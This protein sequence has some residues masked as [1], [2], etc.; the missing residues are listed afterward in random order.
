MRRFKFIFVLLFMAALGVAIYLF[1]DTQ[2][3]EPTIDGLYTYSIADGAATIKSCDPTLSGN[4]IVPARLGGYPVTKIDS[5]AFND[6]TKI[7]T[8][9]LPEGLREIQ[10]YA[11][12]NCSNLI[13]V[14][15]PA[16]VTTID[17][18][19]FSNCTRLAGIWVDKANTVY[20][21]DSFGVLYSKDQKKIIRAPMNLADPYSIPDSVEDIGDRAFYGCANLKK[22]VVPDGI[23]DIDWY[24]FSNCTSLNT[25]VLPTSLVS[26]GS[27]VFRGCS[28]L[29]DVLYKG[30]EDAWNKM[31]I[32][33]GNSS[34]TSAKLQLNY[35][36]HIFD[37]GTITREPTC[38]ELGISIYTCSLCSGTEMRAI[39][40]LTTHTWNQGETSKAATCKDEGVKTFTC[41]VC[42]TIKTESI[43]KLTTHTWNDGTRA[44]DPTC[45]ELGV[46]LQTC[47]I[48]SATKTTDIPK[49]TT[50]SYNTGE[51]T[52]EATCKQIGE[53]TFTCT[54]CED[55][56]TQDIPML[57]EHIPGDPATSTTPQICTSCGEILAPATGEPDNE[58]SSG[59]F[60]AI[61]D[62]FNSIVAFFEELFAS[63]FGIF[64]L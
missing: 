16:S 10:V 24:A 54:V 38:K 52:K 11:F 7:T 59:F 60:G 35:C 45:K 53:M 41:S 27:E 42:N 22:I 23:T 37:N 20:S 46:L 44:K 12:E 39:P 51:V 9:S 1:L 17:I 63:L 57:T 8:I 29:T 50:H 21:S 55:S 40:K 31:I 15:I 34:L 6:C 36:D 32:K 56:Y 14:N 26:I 58:Q 4:I 28:S 3:P 19:A 43:A 49:L 25:I 13:S 33:S 5:Y 18:E 61:I 47:K 64:G 30:A 2:K 48:C 62:F